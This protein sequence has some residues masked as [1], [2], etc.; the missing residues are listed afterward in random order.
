MVTIAVVIVCPAAGLPAAPWPGPPQSCP[1]PR[2][3]GYSKNNNSNNNNNNSS[4]NSN[5]SNNNNNSNNTDS[6]NRHGRVRVN[7]GNA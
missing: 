4:N 6:N 3:G 7:Q 2:R 1:W 5:N